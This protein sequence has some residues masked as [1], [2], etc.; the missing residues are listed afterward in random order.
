M[1]LIYGGVTNLWHHDNS[2]LC[3]HNQNNLIENKGSLV[4]DSNE[5]NGGRE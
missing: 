4:A 1:L 5:I 3:R 2:L